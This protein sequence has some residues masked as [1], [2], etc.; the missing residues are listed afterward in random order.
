MFITVV[1]C[2]IL[3]QY[4]ICCEDA[5]NYR[6]PKVSEGDASFDSLCQM[7]VSDSNSRIGVER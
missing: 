5:E 4:L 3:F 2:H 7:I 6:L 1:S